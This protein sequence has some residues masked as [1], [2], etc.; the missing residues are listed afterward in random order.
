MIEEEIKNYFK[1]NKIYKFDGKFKEL[2]SIL[3]SNLISFN[4]LTDNDI[5]YFVCQSE[6]DIQKLN[7]SRITIFFE[8]TGN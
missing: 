4:T 2:E 8:P 5:I 7:D 6:I 3:H 1:L